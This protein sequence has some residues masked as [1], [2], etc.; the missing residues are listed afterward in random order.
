[1]ASD[2]FHALRPE[3]IREVAGETSFRR[4]Q[5]YFSEGRVC[6]LAVEED[7][8]IAIVAGTQDDYQVALGTKGGQIVHRCSCPLG[9]DGVFCK[10]AVTVVLA[11][12][13][14]DTSA[15][16]TKAKPSDSSVVPP[17][18]RL[19]ELRSWLRDQP[20]TILADLLWE[21][22]AYD[23]RLREK[24]SRR[25][26]RAA[27][28]NIDLSA[29][30]KSIDR[31]THARDFI[32]YGEAWGYAEKVR[33]SVALLQELL[34]EGS[35]SASEIVDL[36]EHALA[37]VEKVLGKADDSNG[38]IGSVLAELQALHLAACQASRPDPA[39]LAA[40]LFA[41]ELRSDWDTFHQAVITHAEVS[42]Q[43]ASPPT[44]GSP[45]LNGPASPR[46]RLAPVKITTTGAFG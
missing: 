2:L 35:A 24:L 17:T 5:A 41:W 42:A 22:A 34:D 1:M 33:Q 11:V 45:R 27:G 28:G 10:H 26:V 40:R 15:P 23:D 44:A 36:V 8:V 21:T 16:L 31:A 14:D 19:E 29:Y 39:E 9:D 7:T 43:P 13:A 12:Q 6:E 38:E 4:G 37:R 32:E 30:R 18:V 20:A 3:H 25:A 46:S